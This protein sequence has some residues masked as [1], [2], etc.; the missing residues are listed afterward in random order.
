MSSNRYL[1]VVKE[2]SVISPNESYAI[3]SPS[4]ETNHEIKDAKDVKETTSSS[5]P[6][7]SSSSSFHSITTSVSV[8]KDGVETLGNFK[9]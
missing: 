3:S 1:S 6:T 8:G 4:S 7:R 2:G 9:L 5:A